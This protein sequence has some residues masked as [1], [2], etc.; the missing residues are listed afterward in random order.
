MLLAQEN[1]KKLEK[2][3]DNDVEKIREEY[4]K[5]LT[6][7][8]SEKDNLAD[9]ILRMKKQYESRLYDLEQ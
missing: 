3:T 9:E 8:M 7:Y 6:Q 4:K 5:Q 1:L 2:D